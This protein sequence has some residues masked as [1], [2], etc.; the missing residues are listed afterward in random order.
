MQYILII[1][2]LAFI[3]LDY[4]IVNDLNENSYSEVNIVG[5]H[6]IFMLSK[7]MQT[8]LFYAIFI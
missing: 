3:A 4:L 2:L 8:I 6:T 5:V 1:P 7:V